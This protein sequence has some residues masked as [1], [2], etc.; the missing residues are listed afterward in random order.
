[1][2]DSFMIGL[3]AVIVEWWLVGWVEKCA[4][5]WQWMASE[6]FGALNE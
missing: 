5:E 3:V 2:I 4:V 6:L 1:M